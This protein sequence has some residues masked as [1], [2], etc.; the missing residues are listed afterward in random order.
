MLKLPLCLCVLKFLYIYV[1]MYI[2]IK[3]FYNF[4]FCLV[5]LIVVLTQ[6]IQQLISFN[7]RTFTLPYYEILEKSTEL[8]SPVNDNTG[9]R[10]GHF[11]IHH[12]TGF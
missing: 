10:D 9:I 5:I 2:E 8:F 3:D 1:S 7:N 12:K 6:F 4:I 11:K